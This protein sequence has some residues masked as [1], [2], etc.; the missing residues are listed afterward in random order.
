MIKKWTYNSI[1]GEREYVKK[2]IR[3]NSLNTIDIGASAM[4]WSYPECKYVA[5]SLEI[6]KDG[7]T[8]F[9]TNL[10][11]K[12]TW[13]N[14]EN[15]VKENGKFDFSI[16]SHT[17]EDIF[18]PL[19]L[20]NLLTSISTGGFIAIP[21][22]Y[23]EFSFLYENNYRGNAHHK[24]IFDIIDNEL[25]IYPKFSWIE[26]NTKSDC[27]IN[28]DKGRELSFFWEIDIPVS[29]FGKGIPFKSD[30]EL[31]NEFYNQLDK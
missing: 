9:K 1:G 31:I 14:L 26:T 24:Q 17:L 8:F 22:K 18:N 11:N 29:I 13:Q 5:D 25:I 16:C 27:I 28:S 3:D 6:K 10:E 12:D 4:F 21:S 15:Y 30:S 19:D 23:D 20:I 2:Y 7:V